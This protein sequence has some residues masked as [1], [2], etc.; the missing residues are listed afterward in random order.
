MRL[1]FTD[2]MAIKNAL[3]TLRFSADTTPALAEIRQRTNHLL[4]QNTFRSGLPTITPEFEEL[5]IRDRANIEEALK[6][7]EKKAH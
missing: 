2:T 4:E 6:I 7:L 3:L 1:F 5:L